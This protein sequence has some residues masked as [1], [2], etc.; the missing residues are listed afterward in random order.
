MS[1]MTDWTPSLDSLELAL[2]E[3]WMAIG[4][5]DLDAALATLRA[6]EPQYLVDLPARLAGRA[7][8]LIRRLDD[9]VR[10]LAD[11]QREVER[12]LAKATRLTTNT[13]TAHP[14]YIDQLA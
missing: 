9:L 4:R 14:R 8:E 11:A 2:D 1:A 7:S 6:L 10:V 3:A 12:E 13:G 5:Q